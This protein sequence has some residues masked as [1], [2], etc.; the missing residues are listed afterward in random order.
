[1]LPDAGEIARKL[2]GKRRKKIS[3]HGAFRV[4]AREKESS[5]E[6]CFDSRVLPYFQNSHPFSYSECDSRLSDT[7]RA[8]QP[9]DLTLLSVVQ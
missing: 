9:D 4:L 8:M 1:M 5:P 3:S 2:V 6:P 7:R